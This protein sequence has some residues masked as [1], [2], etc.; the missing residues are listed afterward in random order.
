MYF[1]W[2][3]L[4]A[5]AVW[6]VSYLLVY[7]NGPWNLFVRIRHYLGHGFWGEV[8]NCFYCAS[9]WVALPFAFFLGGTWK[10]RLLLWPAFS[11]GAILLE[12]IIHDAGSDRAAP[13]IEDAPASDR[14]A[15]GRGFEYQ[16]QPQE[17]DHV[18]RQG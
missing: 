3:L 5:L 16:N 17:A 12:R 18:L 11:A 14:S 2:F 15:D 7:E 6:R 13:Y 8:T 10:Q 9:V 1:Y 4:G